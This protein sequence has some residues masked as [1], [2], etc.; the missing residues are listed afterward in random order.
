MVFCYQCSWYSIGHCSTESWQGSAYIHNG[1][2]RKNQ[3]QKHC[4]GKCKQ[5]EYICGTHSNPLDQGILEAHCKHTCYKL[6]SSWYDGLILQNKSV[7]RTCEWFK[8]AFCL[9]TYNT[10]QQ[11]AKRPHSYSIIKKNAFFASMFCA[12]ISLIHYGCHIISDVHHLTHQCHPT[13]QI[14]PEQ[15]QYNRWCIANIHKWPE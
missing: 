12:R 10:V 13:K 4:Q 7:Y 9:F 3:R 15:T 14:G 8:N 1:D 2:K 5:S 6:L 11:H